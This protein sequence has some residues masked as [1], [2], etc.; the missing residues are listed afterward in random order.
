[1]NI[2]KVPTMKAPVTTWRFGGGGGDGRM[3]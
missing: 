3:V 1:M 2:L